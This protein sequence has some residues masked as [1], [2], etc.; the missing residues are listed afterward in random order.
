[1]VCKFNILVINITIVFRYNAVTP[2][3]LWIAF[4]NVLYNAD[5]ELDENV[6]VTEFMKSWTEQAGYP[7]VTVIKVN[8]TFIIS[9][10]VVVFIYVNNTYV[11]FFNKVTIFLGTV[12]SSS[13]E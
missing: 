6:S 10:V 13:F 3:Q 11:N 5:F 7:L 9:Q 8:D 2:E 12:F 1:M 4:E